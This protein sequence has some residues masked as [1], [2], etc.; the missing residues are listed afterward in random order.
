MFLRNKIGL[1]NQVGQ[2]RECG[3]IVVEINDISGTAKPT[4]TSKPK[5]SEIN[6][7]GFAWV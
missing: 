2:V 1:R 3:Q 7:T 4:A 5:A 6:K